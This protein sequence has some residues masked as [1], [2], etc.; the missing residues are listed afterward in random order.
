MRPEARAARRVLPDPRSPPCQQQTLDSSEKELK[1][2]G[3]EAP[4]FTRVRRASC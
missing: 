4:R 2:P 1:V 3:V